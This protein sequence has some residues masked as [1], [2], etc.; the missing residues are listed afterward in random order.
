MAALVREPA[1]P[2]APAGGSGGDD[3]ITFLYELQEGACPR[4][5]GLQVCSHA[6]LVWQAAQ[7]M[8]AAV[9]FV[10]C[11]FLSCL[12]NELTLTLEQVSDVLCW[13]QVARLAGIPA[14]VVAAAEKAGARVEHRLQVGP[15]PSVY[16][17][18]PCQTPVFFA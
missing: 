15:T 7:A 6:P 1:E 5:Y 9:M 11:T 10:T 18:M 8:A 14:P 2:A 4:S 3:L 16:M 12:Q 17:T 13:L